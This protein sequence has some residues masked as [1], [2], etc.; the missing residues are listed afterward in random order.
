MHYSVLLQESLLGLSINADGFYVDG[1]FGRGGHSAEVLKLLSDQGHLMAFDK[2]A[3]AIAFGREKFSDDKRLSLQHAS[4][5]D[6]KS[7]L[8]EHNMLGK[9]DGILLDLG[10]SSPQLDVADRGFSFLRDGPLDM[11]MDN[12]S[13]QTVAQWLAIAERWEIKKVLHVYGEEK[14]AALIAKKIVERR[15]EH[16]FI[17]TLDLAD[18]I[19][20]II[21]KKVQMQSKKHAATRSFQALRIHINKELE[22]LE[23][24]LADVVEMLK[25]GGRLVVISFHSL[26]DRIVKHFIRDQERGPILPRNIPIIELKRDE[27]VKSVGKKKAIKASIDELDENIRSRSAVMRVAEKVAATT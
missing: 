8:A 17:T 16:P 9:V 15:D 27:H 11:R 12:S 19:E 7:V 22:D 18:F 6:M 1:T 24:L 14:F 10:V 4:F 5:A 3:D 23:N 13:G 20:A 2:D 21:P 25:P 26:E